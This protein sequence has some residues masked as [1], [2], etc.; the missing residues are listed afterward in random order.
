[1]IIETLRT[2]DESGWRVSLQ[3]A[4]YR[5]R[6]RFVELT[7]TERDEGG[8]RRSWC[9]GFSEDPAEADMLFEATAR[10][11]RILTTGDSDSVDW[12]ELPDGAFLI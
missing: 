7:R 12:L 6:R 1:V 11:V 8:P 5:P 3:H 10:T 2:Q 9:V 4:N